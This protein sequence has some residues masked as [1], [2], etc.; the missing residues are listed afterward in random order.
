MNCEQVKEKISIRR[1]LESLGLFP[2]KENPRSAF[3]YALDRDEKTAS[4]CVDFVKNK[5]FDFGTGKSFDVVS[6]V[7]QVQRCS[8]SDALRY[9]EKF[10]SVQEISPTHIDPTNLNYKILKVKEIAHAA[11]KQYLKSRKVYGQRAHVKEVHYQ[12]RGKNYFGIGFFNSSGG[13]EIRN[14]Y[15]KICLGQKDVT[16]ITTE[17]NTN[18]EVL[19]FEGFFDYLTYRMI[20]KDKKSISDHLIL[21][22]TAMLFKVRNKLK[23]YHKIYLFFDNDFNGIATKKMIKTDHDN[24]EDCSLLYIDFKDLNEWF[25]NFDEK[26]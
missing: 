12:I 13:I 16:W 19:I 20:E 25:C 2:A 24:V 3:Y 5:A 15:A 11:L 4:L 26:L 10:N 1:V 21:N 6:I 9:L 18:N 7:Q 8:V 17:H 23:A 14:K 22:S